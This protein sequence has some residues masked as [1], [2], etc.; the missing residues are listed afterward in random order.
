MRKLGL[1]ILVL[2]ALAGIGFGLYYFLKPA[3]PNV[4]LE[5]VKPDQIFLG[6]PFTLT[7]SYSNSSDQVLK[8]SK[9][10]ILLPPEIAFLGRSPDQ[11]GMD[12]SLGDIGPGSVNQQTI[13]LIALNGAQSFKRITAKLNYNLAGQTNIPFETSQSLDL[14]LGSPAVSLTISSPQSVT[15]GQNFDINVSYQNATG[16]DLKDMK[17]DL[18]YPPVF[19]FIKTS[20]N[21]SVNNQEWALPVLSKGQSEQFTVTGNL[22]GVDSVRYQFVGNI[23][24]NYSGQT[25]AI[26]TQ[27]S[28]TAISPSPLSLRPTINGADA[29]NYLANPGD[30]LNYVI[31]FKNNSQVPLSNLKLSVSMTGDMYD[32]ST[33]ET[34]AT[35]NSITNTLTWTQQNSSGLFALNSGEEQSVN[36][37]IKLKSGYPIRRLG[38]KNFTLKLSMNLE[39]P[40]VPPGVAAIKTTSLL[41]LENKV[42]GQIAVKTSGFFYDA[43]SGILNKGPYPP[44]ANQKTQYTIHWAITDYSDDASGTVITANLAP[45]V[46][47]TGQI[48]GNSNIVPVYDPST[49]VV[50][51]NVGSIQA[52]KGVLTSPLETIFQIE[53]TPS[54]VQISRD[55]PLIGDTK[56]QA[57]DTFTGQNLTNTSPAINSSIPDDQK[58]PI[59]TNRTV[60]P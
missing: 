15:S 3:V 14:P 6:K 7:V 34:N 22:L 17:L 16:N 41:D 49:G 42:N 47:F 10:S 55:I 25:Y 36:F 28:E 29:Q 60:R 57:I 51:W 53:A 56:I 30:A 44:K 9:L 19:N 8:N 32:F 52:T 58:L 13:N 27:S 24:A 33:L 12:Q 23:L 39:S 20:K 11:R 37:R 2:L 31:Y 18:N 45:G 35:Y 43:A 48:K 26:N 5:F 21:N 54:N 4:S 50:T 1:W 40:T 38:D 59:M 46:S